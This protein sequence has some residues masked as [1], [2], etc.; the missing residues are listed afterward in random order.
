VP[1]RHRSERAAAYLAAL[2]QADT[3]LQPAAADVRAVYTKGEA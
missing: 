2:A 3:A 1:E